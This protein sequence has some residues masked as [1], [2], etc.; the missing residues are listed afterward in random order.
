MTD[1]AIRELRLGQLPSSAGVASSSAGT[2]AKDWDS[3]EDAV[4]DRL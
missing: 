3:E 4:Y 1:R 2:F